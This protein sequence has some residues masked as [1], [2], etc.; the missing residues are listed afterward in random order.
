MFADFGQ[1]GGGLVGLECSQISDGGGLVGLEC[2]QGLE[3]SQ[4]SDT[5]GLVGLPGSLILGGAARW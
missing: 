4:I 1:H 2:W 5:G 3:Y